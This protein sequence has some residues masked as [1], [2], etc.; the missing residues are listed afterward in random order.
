[1]GTITPLF[2]PLTSLT[3]SFMTDWEEN[4]G[5]N[6]KSLRLQWLITDWM[7][8]WLVINNWLDDHKHIKVQKWI[9]VWKTDTPWFMQ[10]QTYAILKIKRSN[11][12]WNKNILKFW[13]NLCL[14]EWKCNET[15]VVEEYR[16]P[17]TWVVEWPCCSW[18][19]SCVL[20]FGF[21]LESPGIYIYSWPYVY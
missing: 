19:D 21:Q 16:W 12:I 9:L 7:I 6:I 5:S 4:Q 17:T 2:F 1:M 13:M 18:L 8:N 11:F 15:K 3:S 14:W 20:E 10:L